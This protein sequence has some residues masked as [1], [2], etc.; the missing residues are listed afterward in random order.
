MS[1]LLLYTNYGYNQNTHRCLPTSRGRCCSRCYKSVKCV[2][3][4]PDRS[5]CCARNSMP[6]T[7]GH[8][9]DY[10][11]RALRGLIS[12]LHSDAAVESHYYR[13]YAFVALLTKRVL[14][15]SPSWNFDSPRTATA[16]IQ[17]STQNTRMNMS[18]RTTCDVTNDVL[19]LTGKNSG[20]GSWTAGRHQLSTCY[21][22][23][24]T[25]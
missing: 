3:Y 24:L 6:R 21:V 11:R 8:C 7:P 5:W 13:R 16:S 25:A 10:V 12:I 19:H 2:Q 9:P 1:I 4:I 14:L 20:R 22:E 23:L 17:S 15:T 18:A